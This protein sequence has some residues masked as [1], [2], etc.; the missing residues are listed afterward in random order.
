MSTIG[1]KV[2]FIPTADASIAA[3]L[4][5]FSMMDKSQLAASPNGIGKSVLCP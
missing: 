3:I 2:Q 4:A 5:E 1:A